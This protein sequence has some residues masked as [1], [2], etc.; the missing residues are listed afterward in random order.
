MYRILLQRLRRVDE[1]FPY[2]SQ[3]ERRTKLDRFVG[4]KKPSWGVPTCRSRMT[5]PMTTASTYLMNILL[6]NT[7]P[8]DQ[9]GA[10]MTSSL[11][12]HR[13][14]AKLH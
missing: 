1:L 5:R 13:L 6:A 7:K 8:M 9:P 2:N 4:C 3:G 11:A 10:A 14:A 12:D